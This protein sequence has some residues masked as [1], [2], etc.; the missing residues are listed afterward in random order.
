[1]LDSG[2]AGLIGWGNADAIAIV[3]PGTGIK[4]DTVSVV[5]L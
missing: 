4:G 1:M 2:P 3:P 5:M